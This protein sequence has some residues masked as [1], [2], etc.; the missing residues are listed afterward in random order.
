MFNR[1]VSLR[2]V[3]LSVTLLCNRIF[4]LESPKAREVG[5]GRVEHAIV[6][7]GERRQLGI[8]NE[9]A[10]GISG[11][12]H[13]L[14]DLPVPFARRNESHARLIEPALHPLNGF[15]QRQ[16]PPMQTG[17]GPDANEGGQDRP[18]PAEEASSR[19][20]TLGPRGR[21]VSAGNF[22]VAPRGGKSRKNRA[23]WL[24]KLEPAPG[25][26]PGTC[27]LRIDCS[28]N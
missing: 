28:A 9:I 21:L 25:L 6:F 7:D 14:K 1:E 4:P 5:V 24:K 26:E 17:V 20:A 15:F 19:G 8:R 10:R 16:R 13:F 22:V 27:R 3:G 23:N 18:A 12:E 11:A 2:R